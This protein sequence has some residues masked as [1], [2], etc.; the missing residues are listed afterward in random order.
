GA[1]RPALLRRGAVS[2]VLALL[3]GG[4]HR[5]AVEVLCGI[6]LALALLARIHGLDGLEVAGLGFLVG[7]TLLV[8]IQAP[9]GTVPLG[10][11]FVIALSELVRVDLFFLVVALGLLTTVAPLAT[12][13]AQT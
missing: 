12:R 5:L 7:A 8:V 11:A 13:Y 1:R 9:I 3:R 10:Y 6:A 4:Q 2:R